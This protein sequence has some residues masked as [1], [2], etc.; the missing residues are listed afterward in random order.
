VPYDQLISD[1]MHGQA[2]KMTSAVA[3]NTPGWSGDGFAYTHDLAKAKQLL[4]EAGYGNGFSFDFLLG[5]GF[6]DWNDDAVLIQAELAKIGVTMNIKNMARAQFLEAIQQRNVPAFI[7]KWT[8]FVNDPGYHL[9]LLLTTGASSNYGNYSNPAV[10]ADIEQ[11]AAEP[12]AAK[13]DTLYAQAQKQITADAPWLYLYEYNRVVGLRTGVSGYTFY[14]D[15][16]LR[17]AGMSK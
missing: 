9:G 6:D 4:T 15:E 3:S 5:S 8:S 11:A 12:D 10:D 13:R 7:G 14:P 16:I 2:K 17:F 1:V